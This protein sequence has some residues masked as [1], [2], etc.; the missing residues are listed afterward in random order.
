LFELNAGQNP[1]P[2]GL[3]GQNLSSAV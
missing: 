2:A 1:L 3:K